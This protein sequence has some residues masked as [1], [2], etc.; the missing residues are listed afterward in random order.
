MSMVVVF[1][2]DVPNKTSADYVINNLLNE[3]PGY[4]IS[5]DLGDCDKVLRVEG[6]A[7]DMEVIINRLQRLGFAC[8]EL[9]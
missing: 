9:P 6:I 4:S 5:F 8:E 7:P 3:Y 1:K 2:T